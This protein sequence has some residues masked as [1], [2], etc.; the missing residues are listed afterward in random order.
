MGHNLRTKSSADISSFPS[1]AHHSH[2]IICSGSHASCKQQLSYLYSFLC[3]DCSTNCYIASSPHHSFP[4]HSC[5]TAHLPLQAHFLA[6]ES[7]P[8]PSVRRSSSSRPGD[9]PTTTSALQ[10][11]SARQR[12]PEPLPSGPKLSA[13][14]V[15]G[16]QAACIAC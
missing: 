11:L 15:V 1:Q 9:N 16:S 8:P 7:A 14:G 5:A 12:N 4:S 3:M 13:N 6:P 10:V 2:W